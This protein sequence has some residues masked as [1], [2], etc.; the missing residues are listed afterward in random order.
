MTIHIDTEGSNDV[1]RVAKI[2]CPICHFYNGERRS[3]LILFV[4]LVAFRKAKQ[5]TCLT[6]MSWYSNPNIADEIFIIENLSHECK[7]YPLHRLP[8]CYV[9]RLFYVSKRE[10]HHM[11]HYL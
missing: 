10:W 1:G 5:T 11:A 4:R 3:G 9:P 6:G 2:D 8:V 7:I